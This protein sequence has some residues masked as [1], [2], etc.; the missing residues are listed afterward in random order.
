M[1]NLIAGI[2]VY[3]IEAWYEWYICLWESNRKYFEF[4]ADENFVNVVQE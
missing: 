3:N 1:F 4:A 2:G